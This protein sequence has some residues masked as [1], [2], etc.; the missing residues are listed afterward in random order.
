MSSTVGADFGFGQI[1]AIAYPDDGCNDPNK[2]LGQV[3]VGQYT[4]WLGHHNGL[5]Y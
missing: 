3:L 5:A 2:R 1:G 4:N